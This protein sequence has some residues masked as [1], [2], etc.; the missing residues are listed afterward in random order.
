MVSPS[1]LTIPLEVMDSIT[2]YLPHRDLFRLNLSCKVLHY[3]TQPRL[4]ATAYVDIPGP[5]LD[6]QGKKRYLRTI[7][8]LER[9][10][11]SVRTMVV[12]GNSSSRFYGSRRT[13]EWEEAHLDTFCDTLKILPNLKSFKFCFF[14]NAITMDWLCEVWATLSKS[15]RL[16]FMET[17]FPREI[18]NTPFGFPKLRSLKLF[19]G[20]RSH[21]SLPLMPELAQLEVEFHR[22]YTLDRI[23]HQL[24]GFINFSQMPKLLSLYLGNI[25]FFSQILD[26]RPSNTLKELIFKGCRNISTTSVRKFSS[27]L[28]NLVVVACSL[29]PT[30]S[31]M[32]H[33][34]YLQ[35]LELLDS[36]EG[37]DDCL[38]KYL[39]CPQLID[40]NLKCR[41]DQR[42]IE[43]A[44]SL[45]IERCKQLKALFLALHHESSK[46]YAMSADLFL[47]LLGLDDL[48]YLA[49]LNE[50]MISWRML[51]R[52]MEGRQN[53]VGLSLSISLNTSDPS[54]QCVNLQNMKL[55]Y[56]PY[57]RNLWLRTS[58]VGVEGEIAELLICDWINAS[59]SSQIPPALQ[60]IIVEGQVYSIEQF[61][62]GNTL[63]LGLN[64]LVQLPPSTIFWWM[65][66]IVHEDLTERLP[67]GWEIEGRPSWEL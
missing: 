8:H 20:L 33:L 21:G 40:L 58:E 11:L 15:K 64:W 32:V 29:E 62:A 5:W 7:K 63:T 60:Q 10:L 43:F 45:F 12:R 47:S 6:L 61:K 46:S 59:N 44:T 13:E 37:G 53:L 18:E 42:E 26:T 34:P 39:N 65:R 66:C 9:N 49:F 1:L 38:L 2:I 27:V 30:R 25:W 3:I 24:R 50:H 41:F 35:T 54:S 67:L 14:E 31:E 17:N 52:L 22:D 57:L 23:S 48:H 56:S 55:M 16:T 51:A 19:V 36:Q 4:L 28:R